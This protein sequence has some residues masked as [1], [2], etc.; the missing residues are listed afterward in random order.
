MQE[1][2]WSGARVASVINRST[3]LG[4]HNGPLLFTRHDDDYWCV[5]LYSRVSAW[6]WPV[7]LRDVVVAMMSN[8]SVYTVQSRNNSGPKTDPWGK[9][10]NDIRLRNETRW[11]LSVKNDRIH[12][13]HCRAFCRLRTCIDVAIYGTLGTTDALHLQQCRFFQYTSEPH[14]VWL[15]SCLSK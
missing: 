15:R 7:R 11:V 2:P 13:G 3:T 12:A 5:D 1:R 10:N 8:T 4:R 14:K 9:L 6:E